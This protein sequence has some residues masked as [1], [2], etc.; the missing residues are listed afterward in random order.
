VKQ[1]SPST[2]SKLPSAA[3]TA[4]TDPVSLPARRLVQLYLDR[5]ETYD[6]KGPAIN[7]IITINPL[8]NRRS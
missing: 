4:L 2:S 7:A 1:I 3:S 5:I 8:A 6:K